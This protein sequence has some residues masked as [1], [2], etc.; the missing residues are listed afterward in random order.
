[1]ACHSVASGWVSAAAEKDRAEASS[2]YVLSYYLGSSLLGALSGQFFD[3]GW[4][5]LIGWLTGLYVLALLITLSVHHKARQQRKPGE[6]RP[7]TGTRSHTRAPPRGPTPRRPPG[8]AR[9]ALPQAAH[10]QSAPGHQPL[11]Q[12]RAHRGCGS[13]EAGAA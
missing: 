11:A 2:T 8:G 1:F 5:A 12:T 7:L 6:A 3:I 4:E 9:A 10:P 13:P